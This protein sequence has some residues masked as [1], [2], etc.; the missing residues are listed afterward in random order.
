MDITGMNQYLQTQYTNQGRASAADATTRSIGGISKNSSR[1]DIT[2]AVKNFETFMMEKVIKEMKET[3]TMEE[4][5]NDSMSMYKD[6]YLDQSIT[7]IASQ[8]VDQIGGDLT[9]DLVD[10]I[11]RNYG[12]TGTTNLPTESSGLDNEKV[13][14]DI[15]SEN[16]STVQ[17]VLT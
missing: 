15:A 2:K 14:D 10:Q 1:E 3:M 12:I 9:D 11:M 8:M 17:E 6:L 5:N 7:Q 16:T 4:K 13:S